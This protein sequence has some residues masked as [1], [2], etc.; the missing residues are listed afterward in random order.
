[1]TILDE[2]VEYKKDLIKV[3]YYEEKLESLSKIDVSHKTYI[4]VTVSTIK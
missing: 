3:G 1:M 4:R 2:I